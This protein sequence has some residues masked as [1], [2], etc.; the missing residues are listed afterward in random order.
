MSKK[1]L[2]MFSVILICGASALL[3]CNNDGKG[4][5][6][7]DNEVE[8]D[9]IDK[10][11]NIGL[12]D[13]VDMIDKKDEEGVCEI[14][15]EEGV[16]ETN[17]KED[18]NATFD[19]NAKKGQLLE[20]YDVHGSQATARLTIDDEVIFV[21]SVDIGKNGIVKKGEGDFKTPTGTLHVLKAFGVKANPG[22]K[23]P[24]INV[25]PTTYA[26]D[27][28]CE[29]YNKIIDVSKVKHKCHGEEMYKLVPQYNYGLTTDFNAACHWPDGSN[30]FIHCKGPRRYTGGCIAFD[31][32][33]MIEIL[34]RCDTSLLVRISK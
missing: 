1:F 3:S 10:N 11:D 27:D 24:Y 12:N 26:C 32:A 25:T 2:W 33:K 29:Y 31:E 22:T 21:T 14:K 4:V 20:V 19:A 34:R 30:I 17:D 18:Q 28:N 9:T 13:T 23:F 8:M 7:K 16:N 15:E 5:E 6:K